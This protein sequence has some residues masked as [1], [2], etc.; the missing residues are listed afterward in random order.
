M[1][2]VPTLQQPQGVGQRCTEVLEPPRLSW[3]CY[4]LCL[5]T[6]P[7]SLRA[8]QVFHFIKLKP[9]NYRDTD[10][11]ASEILRTQ[12]AMKCIFHSIT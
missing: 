4:K 8:F 2:T 5:F 10:N 7:V 11:K 3:V 1:P 6:R 12:I 9:K